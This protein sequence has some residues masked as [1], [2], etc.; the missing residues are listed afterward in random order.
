VFGFVYLDLNFCEFCDCVRVVEKK[1]G[2]DVVT[3]LR[4]LGFEKF[5]WSG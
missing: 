3:D 4:N 2:S 5:F 1:K